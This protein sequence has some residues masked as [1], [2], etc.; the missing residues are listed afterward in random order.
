[1]SYPTKLHIMEA[2]SEHETH[3][4]YVIRNVL[5]APYYRWKYQNLKTDTV[6]KILLKLEIAGFV[7]RRPTSYQRQIAWGL[8][9]LG[10]CW[11]D[12]QR[13]RTQ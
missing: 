2:L 11:L 13:E 10:R 3:V 4:T 1:M 9:E 5:A 8:T 7:D 12:N 6:R